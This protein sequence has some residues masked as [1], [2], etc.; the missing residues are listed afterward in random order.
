M[1]DQNGDSPLLLELVLPPLELVL[2]PLLLELVL[3][4]LLE[5]VLPPLELVLPPLEL[6]LEPPLL[7]D[8]P[9]ERAVEPPPL[10]P[11]LV[12]PPPALLMDGDAPVVF[13]DS[14]IWCSLLA[15]RI[16]NVAPAT[17]ASPIKTF[18][19]RSGALPHDL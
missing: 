1:L 16:A 4:P 10:L 11:L 2:E 15:L 6:V 19:V 9:G 5:L 7:V 8:P 17:I 18:P 3:P 13:S 12:D 14:S